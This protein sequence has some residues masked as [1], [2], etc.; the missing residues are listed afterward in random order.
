MT[1]AVTAFP[2]VTGNPP[3]AWGCFIG[4]I[5][6][7]LG[8]GGIKPCVSSFG[9]DQFSP[10]QVKTIGRFFSVFYFTINAGSVLSMFLTPVLRSNVHCYGQKSC[11]PLAFGL[12]AL[13]MIVATVIFISGKRLYKVV[14]PVGNVVVKVIGVSMHAIAVKIRNRKDPNDN[15]SHWLDRAYPR[16]DHAFIEDSKTLFKII[17]MFSPVCLFWALYDQQGSR[18]IYQAMLMIPT[19][20]IFGRSFAIKPE[21]MGLVNAA[22]ILIMIPLFDKVIYPMLSGFGLRMKPLTRILW[23]MV[24]GAISFILAAILQFAI[25]TNGVFAPSPD[26]PSILVCVEGCVHVLFQVPQYVLLTA[27][28]IMFSITGLEFAYNQAPDSMKSVCQAVWLLT[29][30]MGNLVVI[31]LNELDV[32]KLILGDKN[33]QLQSWNFIFWTIVLALGILA[34]HWLT[35]DY[36]YAEHPTTIVVDANYTNTKG[37]NAKANQQVDEKSE[38]TDKLIAD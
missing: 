37:C 28:E 2:G 26:D 25:M 17:T 13:L 12:P 31:I 36:R 24:L 5:L 34:F 7:A 32:V 10:N 14:R 11:Y 23:G 8:T 9:G 18:W 4:L 3:G 27:G 15:V 29:V 20:R 19:V 35:K 1:L 22:L 16:Y 38:D 30:A 33:K 21:Q 6:L